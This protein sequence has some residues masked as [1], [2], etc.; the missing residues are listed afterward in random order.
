MGCRLCYFIE[1]NVTLS[2][3]LI[4]P[5]GMICVMYGTKKPPAHDMRGGLGYHAGNAGALRK[6][7]QRFLHFL[8]GCHLNLAHPLR[9]DAVL[10]CQVVQGQSA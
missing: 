10:G 4:S 3:N 6:L 5:N 1:L 8:H 9:A 2:F 7:G